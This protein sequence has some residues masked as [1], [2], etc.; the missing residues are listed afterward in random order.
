[1]HDAQREKIYASSLYPCGR[2]KQRP[3]RDAP[4][5]AQIRDVP[6]NTGQLATLGS[7]KYANLILTIVVLSK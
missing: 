7:N 2:D 6:A 4:L 3:V 5:L 1:M